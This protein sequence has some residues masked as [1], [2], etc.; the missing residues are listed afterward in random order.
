MALFL[1]VY[2]AN[3]QGTVKVLQSI[4]IPVLILL[5]SVVDMKA[6]QMKC[7]DLSVFFP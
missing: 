5:T 7:A 2:F 4:I 1:L 3:L 6:C